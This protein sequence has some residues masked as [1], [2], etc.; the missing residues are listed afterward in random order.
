MSE[1]INKTV[2]DETLG[3]SAN[4]SAGTEVTDTSVSA[5]EKGRIP[6]RY[7]KEMLKET[8]NTK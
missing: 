3:A 1:E 5:V 2:G 7:Y 6:Y 4:A 8:F